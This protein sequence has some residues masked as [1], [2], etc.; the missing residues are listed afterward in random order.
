M[1]KRCYLKEIPVDSGPRT[2]LRRTVG[3]WVISGQ[4]PRQIVTLNATIVMTAL[5][6]LRLRQVIQRAD[7]VITDGAGIKSALKRRGIWTER[8]PGV[9]LAEELIG[10]CIEERLPVYCY[11]GTKEAVLSLWEKHA[12]L[13]RLYF[14]DGFSE[15]ENLV[16]EEIIKFQPK[17]L[18]AGLGSPRQ[19]FFLAGL[20]PEL[21][22]TVGIGVG[23]ALEVISGQKS[24]GPAV[25]I[26]H[27]GEWCYRMLR[28]PKKIKLLPELFKFWYHFL[29]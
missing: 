14:R 26:N 7:L 10:F 17:L 29:R 9:E 24:R 13:G 18:L 3:D 11:G 22:E 21:R 5:R 27:G 19:E 4:K 16:R 6:N 23:G 12:G 25:F 8:Y 1:I 2:E 15:D 20:L 28:D